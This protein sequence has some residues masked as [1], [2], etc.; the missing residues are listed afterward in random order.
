V[1]KRSEQPSRKAPESGGDR[2]PRLALGQSLTDVFLELVIVGYWPGGAVPLDQVS[3]AGI[4]SATHQMLA[5]DSGSRAEAAAVRARKRITTHHHNRRQEAASH[6][7]ALF[8]FRVDLE[9]LA[10]LGVIAK[11]IVRQ[12]VLDLSYARDEASLSMHVV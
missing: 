11:P 2:D 8:G 1:D 10:D 5:L 9:P 7:S 12:F 3:T 6:G 4:E